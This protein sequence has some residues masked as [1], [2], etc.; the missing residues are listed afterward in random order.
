MSSAS[1]MLRPMLQHFHSPHPSASIAS[2]SFRR[3]RR[4]SGSELFGR[5][6]EDDVSVPTVSAS[7]SAAA[8][9]TSAV[10]EEEDE[11]AD[12]SFCRDNEL[13]SDWQSWSYERHRRRI[14]RETRAMVYA[15]EERDTF[16]RIVKLAQRTFKVGGGIEAFFRFFSSFFFFVF[17]LA[18]VFSLSLSCPLPL[19]TLF[20]CM[21]TVIAVR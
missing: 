6:S 14:F 11:E 3:S 10:D 1:P 8:L 17:L 5:L 15:V 21:F 2:P 16:E 9:A 12:A 18:I 19:S 4:I 13:V 7:A 20:V